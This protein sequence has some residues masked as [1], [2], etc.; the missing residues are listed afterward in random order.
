MQIKFRQAWF[1]K[2]GIYHSGSLILQ[3]ITATA[4]A[5]FV[6]TALG[7]LAAPGCNKNIELQTAFDASD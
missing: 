3:P 7:S 2:K 5:G 1:Y 6:A 4:L